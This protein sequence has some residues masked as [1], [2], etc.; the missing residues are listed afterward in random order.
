MRGPMTNAE[1][2]MSLFTALI[3]VTGV[4]GALIFNNQLSV[5]Q[6]QLA[7]IMQHRLADV[8]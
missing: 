1:I 4:I 5:M 7:R 6:G 8:V 3:A 2:L